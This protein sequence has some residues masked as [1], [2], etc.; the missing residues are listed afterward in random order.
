MTEILTRAGV[1]FTTLGSEEW[2]CGFPYLGLGLPDEA[3]KA[4]A[5]NTAAAGGAR[6]EDRGHH[7][8][9]L[10]PHVAAHLS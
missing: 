8:P 7:L 6:R 5:H 9:I 10:L 4:A 2:C 1:D 3:A